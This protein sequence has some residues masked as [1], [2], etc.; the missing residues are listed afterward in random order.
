MGIVTYGS[1]ATV[2]RPLG[3]VNNTELDNIISLPSTNQEVTNLEAGILAASAEL[4]G[5]AH[6][7][8]ARRVM[9]VFATTFNPEGSHPPQEAARTFTSDGGILMVYSKSKKL[10]TITLFF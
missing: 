8:N 1:T 6:R 2:Y 9:I 10:I 7:P 5:P 4:K 3:S